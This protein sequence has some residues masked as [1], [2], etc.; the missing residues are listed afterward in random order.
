MYKRQP[1]GEDTRPTE[2]AARRLFQGK[3]VRTIHPANMLDY[4][5][6]LFQYAESATRITEMKLLAKEM[7]WNPQ[8]DKLTPEIAQKLALAAKRVT[9][10]FTAAG[11][12]MRM[13][14]QVLPFSNAQIQGV[15]A[16]V[17]ALKENPVKFAI[18]GAYG[19]AAAIGLWLT[20][21]DEEWWKTMP[22]KEKYGYTYI[23]SL[24]HI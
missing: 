3:V 2:S 5:R 21:R 20:N 22:M 23:L 1:L 12:T 8:T 9:T 16:H 24:I 13:V 7:G 11:A 18:R 4:V 15:R 14:N 17:R 19:S 6:E 10:D